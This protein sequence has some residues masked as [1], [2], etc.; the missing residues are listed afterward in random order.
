MTFARCEMVAGFLVGGFVELA[1]QL[2]EDI[3]HLDVGDGI[4]MQVDVAEPG[5]NQI[6]AVG[7]VELC[8]LLLK[9]EM[10][11]HV[12]GARRKTLDVIGQVG[13]DI[14]RVALEFFKSVA[15]GVVKRDA[16]EVGQLGFEDAFPFVSPLLPGFKHTVLGRFQHAVEPPQDSQRQH[17]IFVFIWPVR[18]AQKIGNRPDESGFSLKLSTTVMRPR[19]LSAKV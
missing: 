17:D 6:E 7:F 5:D 9:T 3:A 2:F 12:E 13:G 1:D 4:G 16:R 15:A 18:A 19:L 8:D 11:K 10:L 14:I